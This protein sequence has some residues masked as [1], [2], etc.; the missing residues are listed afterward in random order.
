M[1]GIEEV[2][3]ELIPA[4]T[5]Y[6]FVCFCMEN[7]LRAIVVSFDMIAGQLSTL[8]SCIL[9]TF[10][11]EGEGSNRCFH[12]VLVCFCMRRQIKSICGRF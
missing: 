5:P 7:N 3:E 2:G 1:K 4:G 6:S 8:F 9:F 11:E 10:D 12:F